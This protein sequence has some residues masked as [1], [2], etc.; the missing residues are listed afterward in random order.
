MS[1][2][3]TELK[4]LLARIGIVATQHCSCNARAKQMDEWGC[5]ICELRMETL[6]NWLQ[7]EAAI[8]KLPFIRL[9]GRVLLKRAIRNA[10]RVDTIS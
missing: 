4:K 1:G 6:T 10:R 7:D 3:G 2:P 8:R 5:D 9:A